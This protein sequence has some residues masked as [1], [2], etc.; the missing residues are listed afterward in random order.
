MTSFLIDAHIDRKVPEQWKKD[1]DCAF[2]KI[3]DR[4]LP[5][6]IVF[7]NEKVIAILGR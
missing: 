6:S 5:A 2:C 3:V 1:E 4:K 7:E